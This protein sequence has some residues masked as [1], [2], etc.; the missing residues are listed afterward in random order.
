[1]V[2]EK[3]SGDIDVVRHNLLRLVASHFAPNACK[4]GVK[5]GLSIVDIFISY[6]THFF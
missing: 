2:G 6:R 5:N 1:M 3:I 4:V